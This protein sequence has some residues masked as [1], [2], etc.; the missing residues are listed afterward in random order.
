VKGYALSFQ[1]I[2]VFK[3]ALNARV[4]QHNK[5]EV[6]LMVEYLK[7]YAILADTIDLHDLAKEFILSGQVVELK[8]IV[9]ELE[10]RNA[11]DAIETK[12]VLGK[13]KVE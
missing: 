7:R 12:K 9:E 1:E 11:E 10:K 4:F 2:N 13:L 5:R 6:I 3:K 8:V